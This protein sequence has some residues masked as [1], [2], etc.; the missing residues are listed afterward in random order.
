MGK[1]CGSRSGGDPEQRARGSVLDQIWYWES[2]VMAIRES[3][4][5]EGR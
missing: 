5:E 3:T 1:R 2:I 4:W